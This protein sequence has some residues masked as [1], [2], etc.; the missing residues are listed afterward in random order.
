[1]FAYSGPNSWRALDFTRQQDLKQDEH[2]FDHEPTEDEL[3][4]A[5]PDEF[6]RLEKL[7]A[8][9]KA[10]AEMLDK[11][12]ELTGIQVDP[13]DGHVFLAVMEILLLAD[14]DT[15]AKL[16]D[17]VKSFQKARQA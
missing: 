1:V 10:K 15:K 3:R 16:T 5:F 2:F 9:N 13:R 17:Q 14:D 8:A 7:D 6:K 4:E 11:V 12:R